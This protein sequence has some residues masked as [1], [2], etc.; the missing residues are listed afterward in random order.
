LKLLV[1]IKFIQERNSLD[2]VQDCI[3]VLSSYCKDKKEKGKI[4]NSL[5]PLL[6][7]SNYLWGDYECANGLYKAYLSTG[8]F[9]VKYSKGELRYVLAF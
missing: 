6:S 4:N 3:N 7:Y 2:E 8:S 5:C 9:S 1:I